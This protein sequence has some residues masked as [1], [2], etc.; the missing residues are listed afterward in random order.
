MRLVDKSFPELLRDALPSDK[1]T[2]WMAMALEWPSD[3][4]P[5]PVYIGEL[6]QA[7]APEMLHVL[8]VRYDLDGVM[9][10]GERLPPGFFVEYLVVEER[11]VGPWTLHR[12][13]QS[14]SPTY[15]EH[16]EP[17][18]LVR[19][20]SVK[21]P[22][23]FSLGVPPR[24]KASEAWW[25]TMRGKPMI[26]HGQLELRDS[27]VARQHLS[28]GFALFLFSANDGESRSYKIVEQDLNSQSASDHYAEEVLR[29]ARRMEDPK[30]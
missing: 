17:D 19:A 18:D 14:A 12:L 22:A 23:E 29:E 5:T 21:R 9:R 20:R 15:S 28:W 7:L 13:S 8:G 24:W 11:A 2:R 1:P 27:K 4:P 6:P 16:E 3:E 25:P 26:F 10:G 30:V